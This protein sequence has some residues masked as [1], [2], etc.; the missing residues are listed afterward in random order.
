LTVLRDK[1][2]KP[3]LAAAEHAVPTQGAQNP[4]ALDRHYEALRVGMHD[5]F[6]E[7]G[8]AA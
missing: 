7:L 6:R 3:L 1:I 2:I 4:T 5:V 8:V